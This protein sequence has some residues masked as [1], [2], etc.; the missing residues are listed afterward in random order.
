[1]EIDTK[2]NFLRIQDGNEEYVTGSSCLRPNGLYGQYY[3]RSV[4][5]SFC[6]SVFPV[7]KWDDST[8]TYLVEL[9]EGSK[10]LK[11]V[12]CSVLPSIWRAFSFYPRKTCPLQD[13]RHYLSFSKAK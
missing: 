13:A 5:Q 12:K 3:I 2:M 11:H 8:R 4:M 10:G 6:A 7:V 1:M 9:G